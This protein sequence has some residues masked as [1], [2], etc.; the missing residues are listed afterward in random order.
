MQL[1]LPVPHHRPLCANR[2]HGDINLVKSIYVTD[3]DLVH[4][5]SKIIMLVSIYTIVIV[6]PT[7]LPPTHVPQST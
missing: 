2:F 3:I 4:G 7:S 6:V 5:C 1:L